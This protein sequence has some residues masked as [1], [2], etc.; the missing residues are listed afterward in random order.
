MFNLTVYENEQEY[1]N[2]EA[3]SVTVETTNGPLVILED[4]QPYMSKIQ[5]KV[6]F[7]NA[8]G[9]DQTINVR[10]GIVYTNGKMCFVIIDN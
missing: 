10:E 9:N 6:V 2:G 5:D 1:F 8:T 7:R 4:H 3:S